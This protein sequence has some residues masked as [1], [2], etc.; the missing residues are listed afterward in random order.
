M[1][2]PEKDISL[3]RSAP[4]TLQCSQKSNHDALGAELKSYKP[5]IVPQASHQRSEVSA[6]T[7]WAQIALEDRSKE[8]ES[9]PSFVCNVSKSSLGDVLPGTESCG[10]SLLVFEDISVDG[11]DSL[12]Q[13]RVGHNSSSEQ[14]QIFLQPLP[15]HFNELC[16]DSSQQG[17]EFMSSEV[18]SALKLVSKLHV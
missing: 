1:S 12:T 17:I 16:V 4:A 15:V 7:K 6:A 11:S 14:D 9:D 2:I 3:G 18:I 5:D 10:S 13:L 8:G